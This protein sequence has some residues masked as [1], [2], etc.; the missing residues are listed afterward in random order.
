M[1]DEIYLDE[2]EEAYHEARRT[3]WILDERMDYFGENAREEYEKAQKELDELMEAYAV[4]QGVRDVQALRKA[5][6][7]YMDR[8]R[9]IEDAHEHRISENEQRFYNDVGRLSEGEE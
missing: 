5:F 1:M 7:A 2:L 6:V 9:K 4:Q 8:Q 3:A